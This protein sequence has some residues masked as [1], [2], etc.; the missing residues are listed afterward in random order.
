[1]TIADDDLFAGDRVIKDGGDYRFEGEIRAC[2]YKK[3]GKVRYV[4]ENADGVL[5]IFNRQQ[6]VKVE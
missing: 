3:N 2:F 6:L 4:V 5:H 1:M